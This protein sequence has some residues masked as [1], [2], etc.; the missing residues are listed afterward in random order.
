MQ[1]LS[2]LPRPVGFVLSGGATLG[3]LQVGMLRALAEAGLAPDVVT[4]TSAGALNGAIVA[5]DADLEAAIAVLDRTWRSVRTGDVFPGGLLRQAWRVLTGRSVFPLSGLADLV[6]STLPVARFDGLR[7]PFGALA[8]N[9]L[10]GH[11]YLFTD[12]PLEP[13]L[14][15]SAALPGLYPHVAVGEVPYWDGG[16][17]MSVPLGPARQLGAASLVVLDVGD[18]CHRT[19]PPRGL[20]S[21]IAAAFGAA[22]R[23]RVLVEA[24]V[25]ADELAILYLPRPCVD[26]LDPLDFSRSGQLI[27]SG[28]ETAAGFLADAPV[29]EP[30]RMVGSPHHHGPDPLRGAVPTGAAR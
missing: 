20:A 11:A 1:H 28:Y 5:A 23:Q 29:P 26:D 8:T 12:G 30:G 18:P 3:A 21:V 25:L 15:A 7:R 27:D 10:S 22:T 24:P 14:L 16:V 13:A 19:R 2:A 4:G 6:A 9:A 17:T